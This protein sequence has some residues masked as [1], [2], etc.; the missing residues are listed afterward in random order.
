VSNVQDRHRGTGGVDIAATP[1]T[2]KSASSAAKLEEEIRRSRAERAKRRSQTVGLVSPFPTGTT[3]TSGEDTLRKLSDEGGSKAPLEDS[4]SLNMKTA[5]APP[6]FA[7]S[8]PP[9]RT[10]ALLE[11]YGGAAGPTGVARAGANG[12]PASLANFIGGKASGPRLGK[13]QGDGRNAPPEAA[14]YM[15]ARALPGMTSGVTSGVT[16]GGPGL[17]SFLEARAN[18]HGNITSPTKTSSLPLPSRN[19][20]SSLSATTQTDTSTTL[21]QDRATSPLKAGQDVTIKQPQPEA[22]RYPTS[23]TSSASNVPVSSPPTSAPAVGTSPAFKATQIGSDRMPTA[24]L[25]RLKSKKMVEQRVR[26][27]QERVGGDPSPSASPVL[28]SAPVWMTSTQDK[29]EA[30]STSAGMKGRWQADR[31]PS[32]TK[33]PKNVFIPAAFGNALPGMGQSRGAPTKNLYA[34]NRRETEESR[35]VYSPPIRLPGMGSAQSPFAARAALAESIEGKETSTQP[36]EQLAKGRAKPKRVVRTPAVEETA[37]E[38][39]ITAEALSEERISRQDFSAARDAFSQSRRTPSPRKPQLHI[40][41]DPATPDRPVRKDSVPDSADKRIA[42]STAALEAL[43]EGKREATPT[44]EKSKMVFVPDKVKQSGTL[45]IA[46][47][48][49]SLVAIDMSAIQ[50]SASAKHL[51]SDISKSVSVEVSIINPDGSLQMLQGEEARVLYETET[52]IITH[53]YKDSAAGASV[54]TKLYA[55]TGT[56][57]RLLIDSGC[58]EAKKVQEIA[59][60]HRA[61]VID[62]RQGRESIELVKLMGGLLA[63]REGSRKEGGKDSSGMYQVRGSDGAIFIDQVDMVSPIL[64][65]TCE[66]YS[67]LL[68]L[69]AHF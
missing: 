5:Y 4:T 30:D 56:R 14:E 49:D 66:F 33:E 9:K 17:A 60:L 6:S 48:K 40:S 29:A 46:R 45:K 57:S 54:S 59:K 26:E 50:R 19:D 44:I 69:A 22:E 67:P 12:S 43:L 62:A 64:R 28:K 41:M 7:S 18:G 42:D 21:R 36:L 20:N 1:E 61:V 39:T 38:T 16:R 52:Q 3:D 35:D 25:T 55:R 68:H 8:S 32:P 37:K 11:R 47:N 63:T 27:A 2:S 34:S 23:Y 58:S 65:V 31:P 51:G 24:S 15:A 13:L 10:N 53:Q